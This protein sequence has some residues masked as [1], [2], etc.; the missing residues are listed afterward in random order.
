MEGA[1]RCGYLNTI[2]DFSQRFRSFRQ[3]FEVFDHVGTH[4]DLFGRIR[5]RSDAYGA[6]VRIWPNLRN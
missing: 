5:M 6:L 4:P 2:A 1:S 3:I